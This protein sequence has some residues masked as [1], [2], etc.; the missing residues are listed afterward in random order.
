MA[1]QASIDAVS[2]DSYKI[3]RYYAILLA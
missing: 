2:F 3:V 1:K